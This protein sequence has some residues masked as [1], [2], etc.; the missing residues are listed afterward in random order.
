MHPTYRNIHL[1]S[2]LQFL[3][4]RRPIL[5]L[6]HHKIDRSTELLLSVPDYSE[7]ASDLDS[8]NSGADSRNLSEEAKE[9]RRLK[10]Y[11]GWNI[12]KIRALDVSDSYVSN[13]KVC[14]VGS[15][16]SMGHKDLPGNSTV[17]GESGI[18]SQEPW[19]T[20]KSE[21]SH[22][23]FNAGIISAIG[24]NNKGVVGVVRNGQL[25]LH[26][27]KI[28][29]TLSSS[30]KEMTSSA[31]IAALNSCASYGSNIISLP[32]VWDKFDASVEAVLKDLY[33]SGTLIVSE[34]YKSKFP[35]NSSHV[36]AV[37]SVNPKGTL[38]YRSKVADL[39]APGKVNVV[40]TLKGSTYGTSKVFFAS[41]HVSG[42]AAL[43]WSHYP[44]ASN[45]EIREC[46]EKSA[47]DLGPAG[48]DTMY[49]NGLVR[50]DLAKEYCDD[51]L[52]PSASPSVQPSLSPSTAPSVEPSM[53]PSS[54]PSPH[55]SA[56]PSALPSSLPSTSP[57][58][59]PSSLPTVEPSNMPSSN[60][61]STP[62]SAPSNTPSSTPTSMRTSNP[63]AKPSFFP[64]FNPTQ[65]FENGY[66]CGFDGT[67]SDDL[68]S[69]DF[70]CDGSSYALDEGIFT[71]DYYCNC[72][73]E[74]VKCG[75]TLFGVSYNDCDD[76][77]N[78]NRI[79]DGFTYDDFYCT[80]PIPDNC[81]GAGYECGYD[82]TFG[83]GFECD[84]C[85]NVPDG[86]NYIV[87][88][89]TFTD[90]L[91][92]RCFPE[93]VKC[94]TTLFGVSYNDCDDCCN[95]NRID[96]GF[97]Y[98]DFYCTGPIPDNC[99]GAGYECGYDG[100]FGDG[101]EC[102]SCCNV[103]DGPNYIVDGGFFTDDYYCKCYPG[104][105]QCGRTGIGGY[106]DCG[107][108]CNGYRIDDGWFTDT[109]Y[110]N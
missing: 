13:R 15:G 96:D 12:K 69:C 42:V 80:G 83:D 105:F 59:L 109:F 87:D 21:R 47:E 85:C 61:T 28:Y 46:L 4:P 86:P 110:C 81:F 18:N 75:T 82:G 2:H 22:G 63:S 32:F 19:Y 41:S 98:D 17:T 88:E 99:F 37:A 62:T 74:D 67:F 23:T 106:N 84:S 36:I 29:S 54:L 16:Y 26:I 60:P 92:C 31:F 35:G 5:I 44:E 9:E 65:C 55:P 34:S 11:T 57:S 27:M 76:C 66:E 10:E 93:D 77:C 48:F 70:C 64:S 102:D 58:V 45:V 49:G 25:N 51:L 53:N 8:T 79:D 33:D 101:F 100:T 72:F 20:D 6:P 14:I 39:S 97:T 40:S 50:A 24:G 94:G 95:G 1:S 73:P 56:L 91:Y 71:D 78:G 7:L 90:E 103:P 30:M 108:C 3:F 104:N 107:S 52:T 89:G 38:V 43:V 68:G